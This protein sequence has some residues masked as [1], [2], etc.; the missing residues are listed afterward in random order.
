MGWKRAGVAGLRWSRLGRPLARRAQGETSLNMRS[1]RVGSERGCMVEAG[2]GFIVV[3]V[4]VGAGLA[5][6]GAACVGP[7]VEAC[8][9][10]VR[11][12]RTRGY[13][14]LPKFLRLLSS[15]TCESCHMT[16]VRFLPCT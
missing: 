7:S 4:G 3:G 8:S 11:V 13:F 5:R 16:C 1:S 6:H 15:Q 2:V 14:I 9:V 12:R 10:V